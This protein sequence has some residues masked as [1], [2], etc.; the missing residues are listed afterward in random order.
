MS[1]QR[2]FFLVSLLFLPLCAVEYEVLT[3]GDALVDHVLFLSDETI[4]SLAGQRGGSALIDDKTFHELIQ[5]SG[6]KPNLCIG[7]NTANTLKGLQALGHKCGLITTLGQDQAGEFFI[8]N[9]RQKGI[10]IFAVPSSDHTGKCVCFVSP[11]GE[12]TMRTNLGA[13]FKRENVSLETNLFQGI[14]H[15]HLEGYQLRYPHL[16]RKLLQMAKA[17]QA[18]ISLDLASFELVEANKEFIW[19]LLTQEGI[20]LLISNQDEARALTQCD[21]K[22]ACA[23]LSKF[24]TIAIVTV[25]KDGCIAQTGDHQFLSPALDVPVI[26]TTGAGDLFLSGF[27]HGYLT[28]ASLPDCLYM[29][30]LLA[31]NVIQVIGAEIPESQWEKIKQDLSSKRCR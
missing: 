16:V 20:D 29:G 10:S 4:A 24:C 3:V 2:I 26:D 30:T 21:G 19:N 12:R 27:L 5:A 23:L 17:A 1:F 9:L 13:S 28:H 6:C 18:T 11:D 31:S 8:N 15:F 7:G 25:G 22:E 14:S